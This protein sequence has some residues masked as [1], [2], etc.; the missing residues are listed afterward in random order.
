MKRTQTARS[1]AGAK[2]YISGVVIFIAASCGVFL[3]VSGAVP[4][5]LWEKARIGA[6]GILSGAIA[7]FMVGYYR[8]LRK[9]EPDENHRD[10]P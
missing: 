8:Y 3:W 9:K 1:K 4:L 10:N 5:E 2:K 7:V 6:G